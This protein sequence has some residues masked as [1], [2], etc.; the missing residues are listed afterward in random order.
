MTLQIFSAKTS[1]SVPPKTVKSCEKTKTLPAE[2]RPVAGDDGVAPRP[3]LHHPEMRVAVADEAVE[4]DEAAR[5][6]GA[7]RSA[8]G[9]AACRGSAG[10]RSAFSSPACERLLAQALELLEFGPRALFLGLRHRERLLASVA[11][12]EAIGQMR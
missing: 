10:A 2:D 4:L 8:R 11:S 3:T 6:R 9:R 1:D 12:L 7:S 5:D